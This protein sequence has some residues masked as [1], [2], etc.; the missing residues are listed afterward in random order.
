MLATFNSKHSKLPSSNLVLQPLSNLLDTVSPLR[1]CMLLY[2][3]TPPP[4]FASSSFAV[5]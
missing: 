1:L 5:L 4:S 3:P 2:A